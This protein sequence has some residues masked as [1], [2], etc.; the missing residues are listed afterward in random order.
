MS[1]QIELSST[2]STYIEVW[3]L[4]QGRGI[5]Q[6]ASIKLAELYRDQ[7]DGSG[8]EVIT[9]SRSFISSISKAKTATLSERPSVLDP[10]YLINVYHVVCMLLNRFNSISNSRQTQIDVLTDN[11]ER[12]KRIFL[13]KKTLE[14][15]LISLQYEAL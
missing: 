13:E 9:L 11:I 4:F 5:S 2:S 7:K 15:H 14:I 10:P 6:S 12:S 1:D 3:T 8:L